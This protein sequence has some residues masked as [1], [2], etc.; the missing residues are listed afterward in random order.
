MILVILLTLAIGLVTSSSK[1]RFG[2]AIIGG[3]VTDSFEFLSES[4]LAADWSDTNGKN[5][6]DILYSLKDVDHS[7]FI[8]VVLVGFSESQHF[9]KVVLP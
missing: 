4:E 3:N 6:T 2:S 7:I 1:E 5:I 8:D 9:S